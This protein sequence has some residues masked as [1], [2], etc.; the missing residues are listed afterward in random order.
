MSPVRDERRAGPAGAPGRGV[1][2]LP[3]RGRRRRWSARRSTWA[4]ARS[5]SSAG[6]RTAA[7]ERFGVTDGATRAS[8]TPAPGGASSTTRTLEAAFLDRVRAAL[9]GRRPLGRARDRLGCCL[10]CELMPWSAKAQELLRDAVRG[11]RRRRPS[12]ARRRRSRRSSR[13]PSAAST[14]GRR[15]PTRFATRARATSAA[16]STP[17]AAT[18]GRS[19]RSTTCKLAPFHLLATE[20]ARPHRQATT[21]GTWRRWPSV[22][23][24]DRDAAAARRRTRVVDVTDPASAGGGRRLVGGAD[25]RAAARGWS[26]SRSTSSRRGRRGLVAAGREVPRAASTCGSSTAR[27]TRAASN[28]ERLRVARPGREAV[29]RAARVRPGRRGAGAVRPR[30]AAAPRPRVRLRRARPGERAGGP[31]AVSRS[32]SSGQH[33]S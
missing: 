30:R 23:R 20:G 13:R 10:D 26:S 16:T 8:S 32:S 6:T 19:S 29:A 11:G 28:L 5:S 1:R 18:A 31:A 12:R 17:T 24:A 25:R 15:S 9:D 3:Q 22:C 33:E 4:R 14:I 7:R 21:S 27:S 2:L